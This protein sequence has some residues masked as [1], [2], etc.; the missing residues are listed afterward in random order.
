MESYMHISAELPV[1]N[2]N[3]TGSSV[4]LPTDFQSS[5]YKQNIFAAAINNT[6]T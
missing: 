4:R 5:P 1:N 6:P 3:Y 2:S